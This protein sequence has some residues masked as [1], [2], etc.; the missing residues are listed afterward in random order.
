MRI[1]FFIVFIVLCPLLLPSQP[2]IS[3]YTGLVSEGEM[4]SALRDAFSL[5]NSKEEDVFLKS[6][7]QSGKVVY[8]SLLNDYV[9]TI[10]DNL[11]REEPQLRE[12]I[13]IFVIKSPEVN[14]YAIGKK[15]IF[16][17]TGLL[18][19]VTNEAE[20]AFVLAHEIVH[21][22][23]QHT[24]KTPKGE[25]ITAYLH[26]H[27]R[28]RE[29]ENEADRFALERYYAASKYSYRAVEGV[30]DVLQYGHLPFNNIPFKRTLVETDFYRFDDNYYLENVKPIRSRDDDIDTLSTHPNVFKRRT[31]AKAICATKEDNGRSDFI[32]S[33][34]L[35][36]QIQTLARFECIDQY[37][38]IHDYGNAFYNAYI[39]VQEMPDNRYLQNAM[40]IATYGLSKHKQNGSLRTVLKKHTDME[41]EIEQVYYFFDKISK[42]EL[43]VLAVRLLW[44]ACKKSS[45]NKVLVAMCKDALKDMTGKNKLNMTLFSDY[46]ATTE[47]TDETK[48]I[49]ADTLSQSKYDRIKTTTVAKV[50]PTERFKTVNYMLVDLKQDTAFVN[51]VQE[52][53]NEMEDE[54]IMEL[55]PAKNYI[56]NHDVLIFDPLVRFVKRKAISA[57]K[58]SSTKNTTVKALESS[59]KKLHI[60]TKYIAKEQLATSS[61]LQYNQYCKLSDWMQDL[62]KCEQRMVFFQTT[63]MDILTT[64]LNCKHIIV[65]SVGIKPGKYFTGGRS[66]DI[67]ISLFCP[68]TSPVFL[69]KFF[70]LNR[71]AQAMVAV[72]EL[73]TG[74]TLFYKEQRMDNIPYAS[75]YVNAFIYDCLY[76]LK[77]GERHD[78][79]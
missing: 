18:A 73:E 34:T 20:L 11:L 69:S 55:L 32:Q 35:F 17:N 38:T 7:L 63:N 25:D 71:Q 45:E 16:V 56:A 46:P 37:L 53:T 30:F 9:N 65:T 76:Q 47:I 70:V 26:F 14:A 44:Q 74:K 24:V 1:L 23:E 8:G 4:P 50:K 5:N 66:L 41:G 78:K 52:A 57:K 62:S 13:S 31:A 58:S 61:T 29:Q 33:K 39:L 68:I 2:D 77:K 54:S 15:F 3:N 36:D 48:E 19:Q 59:A 43:N 75:G 22:A 42:A 51:L 27:N 6:I 10:V 49:P 79:E 28:S 40:A 64:E 67:L 21:I 12:Q 72:V 60:H